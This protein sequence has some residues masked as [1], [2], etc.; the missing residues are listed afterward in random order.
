MKVFNNEDQ[1]GEVI[2]L[3]SKKEM[4]NLIDMCEEASENN[5]R[6]KNWKKIY[7]QLTTEACCY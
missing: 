1:K 5:K 4:Q 6:K 3:V 2:L 7:C